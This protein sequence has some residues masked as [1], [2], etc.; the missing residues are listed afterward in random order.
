[1]STFLLVAKGRRP[2]SPFGLGQK[3]AKKPKKYGANAP[4]LRPIRCPIDFCVMM[5]RDGVQPGPD[6]AFGLFC[7]V[8]FHNSWCGLLYFSCMMRAALPLAHAAIPGVE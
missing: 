1:M 7:S 3:Q 4:Q 6:L 5:Q 2:N 8:P